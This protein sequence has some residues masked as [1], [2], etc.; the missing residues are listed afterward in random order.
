MTRSGK[1]SKAL[2]REMNVNFEIR[3]H[4]STLVVTMKI[5]TSP[6]SRLDASDGLLD[7]I[8]VADVHSELSRAPVGQ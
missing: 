2:H 8:E 1:T 7:H 3:K 6:I 5:Y 4:T